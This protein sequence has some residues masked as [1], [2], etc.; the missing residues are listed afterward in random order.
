MPTSPAGGLGRLLTWRGALTGGGLAFAGLAAGAGA[1][2]GLRA[3]GVGPFATL[4]SAGVIKARDPL[5][6]ADFDN[7]TADSTLAQSVTEALR[8]DLARSPLV[9]LLE[10]ADV[11][12]A[13]S[14]ME[15]DPATP[16]T[17][18]VARE[19]AER[20]GAAAVVTGEIA[21]L[22][23]GYVLSVRLLATKD[24]ATLLAVRET[25]DNAGGLIA[26]VDKLSK[27]LRE[28]I[29]ESLRT[30]RGGE[31][32]EDVT[33]RSLEALRKY[34]QANRAIDEGQLLRGRELLNEAIQLDSNF[35]MAHRK[36]AVVLSN[37]GTDFHREMAESRRAYELRDRLPERER[38]LATA[39]YYWDVDYDSDK[40]IAAYRQ[41]LDTWPDD[42]TAANNLAIELNTRSRYAEAAEV[43]LKALATSP[44]VGVLYS[45]AMDALVA[46]G[47]MAQADTV[48]ARWG[49][50]QP[51]SAQRMATGFRLAFAEGDYIRARAYADSAGQRSDPSWQARSHVQRGAL[52]R[53]HG[54]LSRADQE[55]LAEV[56][57]LRDAGAAGQALGA[58]IE[59]ARSE[60][61]FRDQPARALKRADSLLARF[62]L[63]SISPVDRPYL[64]LSDFFVRAGDIGR[65]EKM[66][67]EYE[68]TVP[69]EV[70]K[71]DFAR[72]YSGAMLAFA[73]QQYPAALAGFREFK[74]RT[75]GPLTAQYEI[76]HTFDSMGQTDSAITA[77]EAFAT[78][79]Q[80]GPSGRQYD[81]PRTW[82]RLGELYEGKGDRR[83]ALDYYGKFV[84]LWKDADPDLLPKVQEVKKRM[85]AL[86]G[87][88]SGQKLAV[89]P[90]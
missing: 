48:F 58:G 27:R 11:S 24:G 42:N 29:G 22:G 80:N 8:I 89:P 81:L 40:I 31:P 52:F 74:A 65:A 32:L 78:L 35:A 39:Y 82:R 10:S 70:K 50:A 56:D 23:S 38:L 85:A 26:A 57:L 37:L 67:A 86:A 45:N 6:V 54:Q 12:S 5:V 49:K 76:A 90:A 34:S 87:E 20:S 68:R 17:G 75:G 62:P 25:A 59:Y 41:V 72:N 88:A 19:V 3:A 47:K 55:V 16:L 69:P 60:S 44:Q 61:E 43:A 84:G 15:K 4:L 30:I 33:T 63:D 14:R 51:A 46:Q 13:L 1:F 2:M 66:V 79:P 53:L 71:G 64:A 18:T 83:K 9:R 28:G 36:L 73:R 77:Y 7:R 21:P